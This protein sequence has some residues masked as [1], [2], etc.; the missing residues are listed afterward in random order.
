MR[1]YRSATAALLLASVALGACATT[2]AM[3][4]TGG[5]TP[6]DPTS[7]IVSQ[8]VSAAQATCG[9]VPTV[10]TV[11]NIISTLYGPSQVPIGVAT[12]IANNICSSLP[13]VS[14]RRG[15][16]APSAVYYPNTTIVIHGKY[17]SSRRHRVLRPS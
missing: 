7:V 10:E 15:D 4:T 12:A 3:P 8:V 6:A 1:M 17:A 14:S 5:T 2:G 13:K 11:L 9:F 16:A